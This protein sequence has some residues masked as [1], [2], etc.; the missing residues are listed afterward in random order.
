MFD[1]DEMNIHLAQ[2]IQARNELA[3][4]AN[5]KYQIISAKD[6]IIQKYEIQLIYQKILQVF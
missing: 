4:I 6:S 3:R 5:V 2:T 1:G